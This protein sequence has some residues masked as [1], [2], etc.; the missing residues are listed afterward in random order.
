MHFNRK[1]YLLLL[2]CFW[3]TT[4]L[5]AQNYSTILPNE[6]H[7][8]EPIEDLTI[9]D[10][11]PGKYVRGIK[12]DSLSVEGLDTIIWFQKE[13]VCDDNLNPY[14][15]YCYVGPS[16][17]GSKVI[18]K[19]NGD[20][21]FFNYHGD[22]ILIKTRAVQNEKWILWLGD[23]GSYI[24]AEIT[25]IL[26][27]SFLE[28]QDS[29]KSITI[30]HYASDG[31][32]IDNFGGFSQIRLSKSYGLLAVFNFRD[33]PSNQRNEQIVIHELAGCSKD[34]VGLHILTNR[35]VN[36]YEIGDEFHV[37][38]NSYLKYPHDQYSIRKVIDKWYSSEEDSLFYEIEKTWWEPNS[39]EIVN[40][41][42]FVSTI[43]DLDENVNVLVNSEHEEDIILPFEIEVFS[44]WRQSQFS[45]YIFLSGTLFNGRVYI[46]TSEEKY[47]SW[48][49]DSIFYA[50]GNSFNI[51]G[52]LNYDFTIIK[53]CGKYL[54]SV[55]YEGGNPEVDK[56]ELI[57]FK[58]GSE[59]WGDALEVSQFIL[60][61]FIADIHIWPNPS[62]NH[63]K[64]EFV[65]F[66]PIRN[67]K[68]KILN[69]IGIV[70]LSESID[71]N[72]L[73]I[74]DVSNLSPGIYYIIVES[75]YNVTKKIIV[76]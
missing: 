49:D 17:L 76:Q 48:N 61:N 18:L 4:I 21:I 30:K 13:M 44:D 69:S 31:S 72:S 71:S 20:N 8:F 74:L 65:N 38:T 68:L 58:K 32:V 2:C 59:S 54:N 56:D 75:P 43:T 62:S 34:D 22:S 57:Y 37:I 19:S 60:E 25:G 50:V 11:E 35:E 52:Y 73:I 6:I 45:D 9:R 5:Q 28:I 16:W 7:L 15:S 3:L 66:K 67:V 47:M 14:D 27:E 12:T 1:Y 23:D 63:I 55:L 41:N 26:L 36:D 53:G 39:P 64:I 42:T 40:T 10:L 70:C 33:F 24:E 51:E 29:V 46:K